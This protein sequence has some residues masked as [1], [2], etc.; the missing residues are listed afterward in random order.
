MENGA[1]G[2]K[3]T[4]RREGRRRLGPGVAKANGKTMARPLQTIET[5]SSRLAQGAANTTEDAM[6]RD[7][8]APSFGVG[9]FLICL[10]TENE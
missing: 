10:R 3:K 1:P 6:R 2:E 4:D 5:V 9:G 8:A 7:I